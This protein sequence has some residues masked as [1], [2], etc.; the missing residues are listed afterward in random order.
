MES[1]TPYSLDMTAC[2]AVAGSVIPPIHKEALADAMIG[3]K[4][5]TP[6]VPAPPYFAITFT[7]TVT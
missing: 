7:R 6:A 4:V 1:G 3:A 2:R 5:N